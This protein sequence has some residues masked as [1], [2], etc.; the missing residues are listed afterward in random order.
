MLVS[1]VTLTATG[2]QLLAIDLD[3]AQV[4]AFFEEGRKP[5]YGGFVFGIAGFLFLKGNDACDGFAAAHEDKALAGFDLG[6][7]GGKVLIGFAERDSAHGGLLVSLYYV[8]HDP[9]RK[10]WSPYR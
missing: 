7:T 6:Y 5:L 8:L 1:R 2:I 10:K 3:A 9:E 4:V